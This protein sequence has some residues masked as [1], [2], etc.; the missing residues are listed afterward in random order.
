MENIYIPKDS[1]NM[2]VYIPHLHLVVKLVEGTL[3]IKY[4]IK[5]RLGFE[6]GGGEGKKSLYE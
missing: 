2:C 6:Y 3:C 5:S 1:M 4:G